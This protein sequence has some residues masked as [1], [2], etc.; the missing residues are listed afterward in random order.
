MLTRGDIMAWRRETRRRLIEERM[1]M[2]A[3]EREHRAAAAL[4]GLEAAAELSRF[5]VVGLYW[6]FRAEIDVRP[7]A[8]ALIARGTRIG[9]PV[10]VTPNAAVE[11]R[12]WT[13]GAAMTRGVWNIPVPDGTPEVFPAC[14]VVPLVGFD[15]A[16]YRLGYGGGY[17]DRTLAARR[18]RPWAIGL[19]FGLGRLDS[20]HPLG[21]DVPMDG[22]VTES[23]V[24]RH[25]Q[26]GRSAPEDAAPDDAREGFASPA[27]LLSEVDTSDPGPWR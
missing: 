20:I 10:V 18:P 7:L 21:H 4:A 16:G 23:G 14:L 15:T 26:P 19:G 25:A 5:A 6:P 8:R 13:P 22:I 1:A 3:A 12:E 2:P 24:V 9:L 11:F 27:C 17:Y